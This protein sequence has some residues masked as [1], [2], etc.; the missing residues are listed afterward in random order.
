[1]FKF[2]VVIYFLCFISLIF[3]GFLNQQSSSKHL[4]L[5]NTQEMETQQKSN[6]FYN[7]FLFLFFKNFKKL[8][9]CVG[10]ADTVRI[11]KICQTDSPVGCRRHCRDSQSC[12]PRCSLLGTVCFVAHGAVCFFPNFIEFQLSIYRFYQTCRQ[13]IITAWP[14]GAF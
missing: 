5:R 14:G 10:E 6:L 11:G 7:L 8:D 1:M 13:S 3:I 9:T 12:R 2:S 4:L